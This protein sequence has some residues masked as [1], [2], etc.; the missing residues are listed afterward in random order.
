MAFNIWKGKVTNIPVSTSLMSVCLSIKQ[1][2]ILNHSNLSFYTIVNER[3]HACAAKTNI[4][5]L[6]EYNFLCK[7]MIANKIAYIFFNT[8]ALVCIN[9]MKL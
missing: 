8:F 4:A 3:V 5:V 2:E 6:F 7:L 9:N 1:V